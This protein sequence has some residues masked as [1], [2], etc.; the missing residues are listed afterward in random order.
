MRFGY[1]DRCSMLLA[2]ILATERRFSTI[3]RDDIPSAPAAMVECFE[4]RGGGKESSS[5]ILHE[6]LQKPREKN[7]NFGEVFARFRARFLPSQKVQNLAQNLARN[8][9]RKSC[10][11]TSLRHRPQASGSLCHSEFRT[12]K[13]TN[14]P[15]VLPLK[16]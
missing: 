8:L 7:S 13:F 5:K 16:V 9:A 3:I 6:I 11:R 15:F 1:T 4:G 10:D 12:P 14:L 2:S